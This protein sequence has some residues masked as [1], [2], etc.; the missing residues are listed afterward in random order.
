VCVSDE[1][2]VPGIL[3]GQRVLGLANAGSTPHS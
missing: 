3:S 1:A 2:G